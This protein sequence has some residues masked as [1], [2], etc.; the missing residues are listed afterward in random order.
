MERFIAAGHDGYRVVPSIVFPPFASPQHAAVWGKREWC[1]RR[2]RN[3]W[4]PTQ[5]SQIERAESYIQSS[6]KRYRPVTRSFSVSNCFEGKSC[7]QSQ[8]MLLLRCR[9]WFPLH[10]WRADLYKIIWTTLQSETDT[11]NNRDANRKCLFRRCEKPVKGMSSV[12]LTD[13]FLRD[14][15]TTWS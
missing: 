1:N 8:G 10:R 4:T 7:T 12:L 13:W 14:P 9:Q 2:N 3:T 15:C 6:T 5:Q 11:S